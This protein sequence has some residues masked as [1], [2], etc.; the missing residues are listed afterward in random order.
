MIS[1]KLHTLS[2][3]SFL[4][5]ENLRHWLPCNTSITRYGAFLCQAISGI[6][7]PVIPVL[8]VR[9]TV[10]ASGACATLVVLVQVL[11]LDSVLTHDSILV[12][13]VPLD[14]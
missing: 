10:P 3:K 5:Q 8:P 4:R 14:P 13:P 6:R 9:I 1:G 11:C 2:H 7:L 12:G